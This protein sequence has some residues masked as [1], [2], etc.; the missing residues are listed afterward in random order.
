M[1]HTSLAP[2]DLLDHLAGADTDTLREV[3]EHALQRL[4]EL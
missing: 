3:C 1:T 4:I 2:R